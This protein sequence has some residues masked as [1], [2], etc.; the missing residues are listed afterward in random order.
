MDFS[1]RSQHSHRQLEDLGQEPSVSLSFLT[2]TMGLTRLQQTSCTHIFSVHRGHPSNCQGLHFCA[3]GAER[4]G[5]QSPLCIL[6]LCTR[7]WESPGIT[8]LPE[9]PFTSGQGS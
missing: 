5:C 1:S 8:D 3:R 7:G 4:A 6:P 9:Q 2:W